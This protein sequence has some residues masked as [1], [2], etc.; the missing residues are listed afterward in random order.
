M[1][2]SILVHTPCTSPSATAFSVLLA[3]PA[4][5]HTTV[6]FQE[7]Y[8]HLG[9]TLARSTRPTSPIQSVVAKFSMPLPNLVAAVKQ[10]PASCGAVSSFSFLHSG[11]E[12]R[13]TTNMGSPRAIGPN[14]R[15]SYNGVSR[16]IAGQY[17]TFAWVTVEQSCIPP[18]PLFKTGC[19]PKALK[20]LLPG[21]NLPNSVLENQVHRASPTAPYTFPTLSGTAPVRLY[22]EGTTV[23]A[24]KS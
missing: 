20:T 6:S 12:A 3:G 24:A 18:M 13:V 1:H 16:R 19:M 7:A 11:G 2:S 9:S 15:G 8:Q 10:A 21:D 22:V 4:V 5:F 23:R 14:G 17:V